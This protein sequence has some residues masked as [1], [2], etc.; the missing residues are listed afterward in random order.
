L[1]EEEEERGIEDKRGRRGRIG[2]R[3]E[4]YWEYK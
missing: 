2:M 4:E 3:R 1:G